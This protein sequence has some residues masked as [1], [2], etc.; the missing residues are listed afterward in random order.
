[1]MARGDRR[2]KTADVTADVMTPEPLDSD[3]VRVRW[4]PVEASDA[5]RLSRWRGMLDAEELA[6]ADRFHFASDRDT[7]TAAHALARTMLSDATGLPIATWRYVTGKFGKPALA[8][9]CAGGDLNRAIG[10][11]KDRYNRPRPVA[12]DPHIEPVVKAANAS[13]PSGTATFAYG[14]AILLADM[15]PEKAAAIFARA[16]AYAH[17]RVVAGVHYPTD[18]EGGRISASVIHNVLLHDAV[19]MADFAK[20]RGEVRRAIGLQ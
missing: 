17:N 5:V 2:C 3:T 4:L 13:F 12:E 10:P 8:A 6:R 18:L 1:M 11:A 14:T 9:D 16:D 15:V 7:F 19:F 20:A